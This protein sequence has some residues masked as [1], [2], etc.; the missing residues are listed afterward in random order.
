MIDEVIE[1]VFLHIPPDIQA[2]ID[3]GQL[4]RVGSLVK[5]VATGRVVRHLDEVAGPAKKQVERA[6]KGLRVGLGKPWVVVAVTVA[7]MAVAGGATVV[8]VKRRKRA[9]KVKAWENFNAS[10]RAYLEAGNE[11]RLDVGMVTKL[12]SD[13]DAVRAHSGDVVIT[14]GLSLEQ[15]R[16]LLSAIG[17]YTRELAEAS[18]L[19]PDDVLA[20]AGSETDTVV[21]LRRYL[22]AQR[23]IFSERAA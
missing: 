6:V 10:L 13:L 12:I 11:G 17:E 9:Q 7:G 4:I 5:D 23:K 16:R 1:K 8:A 14:V 2:G 19:E 18:S 21:D 20:Q 15:W 22:E 3:S